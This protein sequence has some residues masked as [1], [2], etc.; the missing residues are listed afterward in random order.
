MSIFLFSVIFL[1]AL[2]LAGALPPALSENA[3]K[4]QGQLT[5]LALFILLGFPFYRSAVL[6]PE[7][8]LKTSELNAAEFVTSELKEKD[9]KLSFEKLSTVKYGFK[10]FI[11]QASLFYLSLLFFY[12]LESMTR[13]NPRLQPLREGQLFE[14]L[15]NQFFELSFL[16]WVL[17]GVLGV[18]MAYFSAC[19]L[20][21]PTLPKII[22]PNPQGRFQWYVHNYL[23]IIVDAVMLGP[24]IWLLPLG[25]IWFCEGLNTLFGHYSLFEYPIRS[26]FILG[27]LC[28]YFNRSHQRLLD[29][30][31]RLKI[32]MGT[33]LVI[34]VIM[35]SFLIFLL[36]A[37]ISWLVLSL[38][39]PET[40]ISKSLIAQALTGEM[41]E[42]RLSI[43]IW[44]W[45][46][47]WLP[48]MASHIARLSLG[49]KLWVA[50]LASLIF[51]SFLFLC[52][53]YGGGLLHWEIL[54]TFLSLK[55]SGIK[56]LMAFGILLF[57]FF[58]FRDV[59]SVQDFTRGG[60]LALGQHKR[61][62]SLKKWMN[63]LVILMAGH[64]V[65]LFMMGWLSVQILST[66]GALVML[67]VL[68]GFILALL[69]SKDFLLAL[70]KRKVLDKP[71]G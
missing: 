47:I 19:A 2:F 45:W 12:T 70:K 17:Y 13:W 42:R 58:F 6:K 5:L 23:H 9:E 61:N 69:S 27:L 4:I 55:Y 46:I 67:T 48:W 44:S 29:Q 16:P 60:L 14:I 37:I 8:E 51:P 56:F 15:Q 28:L 34:Y 59:H 33:M 11:L 21:H 1:A 32:P 30:M 3:L 43:L 39:N 18:G 24:F 66:L 49:R 38:G 53:Q 7:P 68:F 35:G 71:Q 57:L 26:I 25:M 22:F 52:W 63:G 50:C 41:Q 31:D 36:H 10:L 62:Y 54:Q 64:M 20:R 65:A 40:H